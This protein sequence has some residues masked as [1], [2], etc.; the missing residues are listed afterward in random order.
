[1]DAN[2]QQGRDDKGNAEPVLT[3]NTLP[4]SPGAKGQQISDSNLA[5][6]HSRTEGLTSSD[7]TDR[8]QDPS[9]PDSN[10]APASLHIPS[11]GPHPNPNLGLPILIDRKCSG[12]FVEPVRLSQL[13]TPVRSMLFRSTLD[14][15]DGPLLIRRLACGEDHLSEQ[16]MWCE[17]GEL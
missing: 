16:K 13:P 8:A 1:V 4:I 3:P 14:E 7:S 5:A 15:M 17:I 10:P 9:D 11:P 2:P 12:Y 6:I